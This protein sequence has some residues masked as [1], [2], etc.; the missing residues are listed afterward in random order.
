MGPYSE[1]GI[2]AVA[3]AMRDTQL[4]ASRRKVP[5]DADEFLRI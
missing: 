5:P 1:P 2:D 3:H 4:E